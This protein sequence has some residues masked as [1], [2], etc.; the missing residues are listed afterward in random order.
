MLSSACIEPSP[1]WD[2]RSA[3]ALAPQTSL[4]FAAENG[5][6]SIVRVLLAADANLEA[7]GHCGPP[8]GTALAR[9][10][11]HGRTQ[12]VRTLLDANAQLE[13]P[14]GGASAMMCAWAED[15]LDVC[16]VLLQV[17]AQLPDVAKHPEANKELQELQ[18]SA[19][20]ADVHE[21]ADPTRSSAQHSL[22]NEELQELQASAQSAVAHEVAD[23]ALS[24]SEEGSEC[25]SSSLG[26]PPP[27]RAGSK[28]ARK[29]KKRREKKQARHAAAGSSSGP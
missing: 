16:R 11:Y 2:L 27:R 8:E 3:R 22:P 18:A 23:P 20:A 24:S 13:P 12:V 21:A 7:V 25:S 1:G 17:G 15:H 10:A 14:H 4:M 5:H 28:S 9:A 6:D 19:Q 26:S 29:N